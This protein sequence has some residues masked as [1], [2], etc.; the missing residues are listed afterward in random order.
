MNSAIKQLKRFVREEEGA[1]ASEY[2]ILVAVIVVVVYLAVSQFDLNGIFN[3]AAN[4]VKDCVN[5]TN[6]S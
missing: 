4:K 6:C 1:S 3:S 5:G 2:A